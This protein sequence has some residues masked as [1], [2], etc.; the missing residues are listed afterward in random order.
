MVKYFKRYLVAV[1]A[2]FGLM[3]G[4][5]ALA[6]S[7]NDVQFTADTTI[8]LSGLGINITVL[9]GA[10]VNSFTVGASTITVVLAGD[11]N[12][13]SNITFDS[14]SKYEMSSD[15][16]A[17]A[18]C[19]GSGSTLTFTIGDITTKTIIISPSTSVLTCSGS[20]DTSGGTPLISGGGGSSNYQVPDSSASALQAQINQLLAQI[21]GLRVQLGGSAGASQAVAFIKDL[22]IG[23]KNDPDIKRLQGFLI[24]KGYLR[25][26]FDTGNY[27]GMTTSAVKA[28]QKAKGIR[29][30][31]NAG[32]L[33][34]AS[35][36][37]DLGN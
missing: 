36:N 19:G 31:G 10:K 8:N 29:Q 32:P 34:R 5:S 13:Y 2:V 24:S 9:N 3:G 26:G 18:V 37:A 12:G 22:L 16:G 1:L 11:S 7:Y 33:T 21:A 35:I 23:S 27:L 6:A 4:V 14:A 30:T 20:T 15:D 25:A 17:K 28:Y